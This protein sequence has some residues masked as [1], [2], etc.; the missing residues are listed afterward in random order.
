MIRLPLMVPVELPPKLIWLATI[1]PPMLLK[2]PEQSNRNRGARICEPV[3]QQYSKTA[4]LVVNYRQLPEA[5]WTTI[6]PHF[7]VDCSDADRAAMADAARHDAK[8]PSL[9]F[10]PDIEA[11][12]REATAATRAVADGW[13]CDLYRRLETLRL[14]A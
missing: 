13:L 6:M 4:A 2:L 14:G 8:T 3:L 11:K 9:P 10:A 1:E 5:L 7:G 12:Q